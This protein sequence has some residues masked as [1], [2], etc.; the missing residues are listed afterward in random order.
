MREVNEVA[1]Q[2]AVVRSRLMRLERSGADHLDDVGVTDTE[3]LRHVVRRELFV[4]L[5]ESNTGASR[6]GLEKVSDERAK[7]TVLW[8]SVDRMGKLLDIAVRDGNA[9]FNGGCN[10]GESPNCNN[11]NRTNLLAKDDP[12]LCSNFYADHLAELARAYIRQTFRP[13]NNVQGRETNARDPPNSSTVMTPPSGS[14][15]LED[16]MAKKQQ[17]KSNQPAPKRTPKRRIPKWLKVT[18]AAAGAVIIAVVSGFAGSFLGVASERNEWP[19]SKPS[20]REIAAGL[21]GK[22]PSAECKSNFVIMSST[23]ID[24]DDGTRLAVAELRR[25]SECDASWVWVTSE[26]A[27]ITVLKSLLREKSDDLDAVTVSEDDLITV[28][29]GPGSESFTEQVYSP[30]CVTF[31]VTILD[32]ETGV[33][34]GGVPETEECGTT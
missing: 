29:S 34:L 16:P 10:H 13:R 20:E 25:G 28:E 6:D 15:T 17:S 1:V 33:E 5:H 8:K 14:A 2:H 11:S 32:S 4:L 24:A 21:D 12:V 9:L 31:Q 22:F 18:M 27:G 19:Y 26:V 30:D 3:K 23:P 7:W